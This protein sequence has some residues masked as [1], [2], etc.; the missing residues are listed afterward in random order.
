MDL[1]NVTGVT[2][3]TN[4]TNVTDVT[5]VRGDLLSSSIPRFLSALQK[6]T[7]VRK[8][9]NLTPDSTLSVVRSRMRNPSKPR[10]WCGLILT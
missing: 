9:R 3:V 7:V 4:V 6:G 5:D 2:N 8:V 1:T 10:L